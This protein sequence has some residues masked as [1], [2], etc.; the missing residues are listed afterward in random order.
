MTGW[1]LDDIDWTSFRADSVDPDLLAV[2]KAAAL[3]EHNG[4]E[5]AVY[6]N[7]I[8]S[9]DDAIRPAIDSWA[10]EEVRHGQALARWASLADP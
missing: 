7:N 9:G 5:Y 2:A 4:S 10:I 3:V 8:F 6:L 1:T